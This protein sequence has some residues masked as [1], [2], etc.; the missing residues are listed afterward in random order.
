MKLTE[1]CRLTWEM[2]C[3]GC[4]FRLLQ[5]TE[6]EREIEL[7][8]RADRN[9]REAERQKLLETAEVSSVLESGPLQIPCADDWRSEGQDTFGKETCR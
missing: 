8:E 2:N 4:L 9:R 1:K 5:M 7:A 6:L 3:E